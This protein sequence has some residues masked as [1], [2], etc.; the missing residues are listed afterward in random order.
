MC[1]RWY[2]PLLEAPHLPVTHPQ[3]PLRRPPAGRRPEI[4][5]QKDRNKI[6]GRP[7]GI[8]V[9]FD[10]VLGKNKYRVEY[11]GR[12]TTNVKERLASHAR[13]ERRREEWSHC[14]VFKVHDKVS[15]KEISQLEEFILYIFRKD[16]RT[17]GLNK[18][19]STKKLVS[20]RV[21]LPKA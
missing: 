4:V 12:S 17:I 10:K 3:R 21:K 9:L 5:P 15:A 20:L 14:T 8:Y 6:P 11:V 2:Q 13:N 16:P 7:K 19:K 18:N 1:Y